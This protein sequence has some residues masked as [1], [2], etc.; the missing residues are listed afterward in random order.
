MT[1]NGDYSY[2]RDTD[3]QPVDDDVL[4]SVIAGLRKGRQDEDLDHLLQQI[5]LNQHT[6]VGEYIHIRREGW[7]QRQNKEDV[8][9]ANIAK[10]NEDL[11][12]MLARVVMNSGRLALHSHNVATKALEFMH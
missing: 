3:Y 1:T 5:A 12:A 11:A 6:P 4:E 9:R 7:L 10:G 2:D 8:E